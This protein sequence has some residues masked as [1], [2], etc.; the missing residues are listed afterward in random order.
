MATFGPTPPIITIEFKNG[1]PTLSIESLNLGIQQIKNHRNSTTSNLPDCKVGS[2]YA[3]EDQVRISLQNM[4]LAD[5]LDP[6]L[7]PMRRD[8]VIQ[9]T[10]SYSL[11]V[12]TSQVLVDRGTLLARAELK[13]SVIQKHR[14]AL[15]NKEAKDKQEAGGD[16]LDSEVDA[17]AKPFVIDS[18]EMNNGS[19]YFQDTPP[20]VK[21]LR[22]VWQDD[23]ELLTMTWPTFRSKFSKHPV[24]K[25]ESR[26]WQALKPFR[27]I[28][29]KT[30]Q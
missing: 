24:G 28:Y 5:F 9:E 19:P 18:N 22:L 13:H 4:G 14:R 10:V 12:K 26:L 23:L 8:G 21:Q 11:N 29:L 3:D 1:N 2:T 6:Y 17:A 20:L 30:K 27:N 7:G 25:S 15:A 16:E